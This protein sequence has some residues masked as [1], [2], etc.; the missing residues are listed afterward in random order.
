MAG[1]EQEIPKQAQSE[2]AKP[3]TIDRKTFENL[4]IVRTKEIMHKMGGGVGEREKR[5]AFGQA[6]K[7][8]KAELGIS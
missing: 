8:I 7:E 6:M 5:W 1:G 4:V 3:P 2:V